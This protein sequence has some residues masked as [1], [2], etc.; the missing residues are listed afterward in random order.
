M[1]QKSFVLALAMSLA[2]GQAAAQ[3]IAF[4]SVGTPAAVP[5]PNGG[6]AGSVM[7]RGYRCPS[8]PTFAGLAFEVTDIPSGYQGNPPP[9]LTT[10]F[11]FFVLDLGASSLPGT[12]MSGGLFY[13]P[14]IAPVSVLAP[15][16][17][18]LVAGSVWYLGPGDTTPC[19]GATSAGFSSPNRV[20]AWLNMSSSVA[21]NL[22]AFTIQS[23]LFDTNSGLI[24]TSNAVNFVIT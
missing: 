6:A 14:M 17:A 21:P 2:V 16:P 24:Y 20:G 5:N 18:P 4:T 10:E 19:P 3:S 12:L 23:V 11:M 22:G 15:T 1:I 9:P 8:N 7:L 13:L